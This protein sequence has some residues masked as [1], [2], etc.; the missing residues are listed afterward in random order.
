MEVDNLLADR[1]LLCRTGGGGGGN[2]SADMASSCRLLCRTLWPP[3]YIFVEEPG[4]NYLLNEGH[5]AVGARV[6]LAIQR[7]EGDQWLDVVV[8]HPISL[9]TATLNLRASGVSAVRDAE[10]TKRRTYGATAQRTGV[11]FIPNAV[12][13]FELRGKGARVFLANLARNTAIAMVVCHPSYLP[14]GSTDGT[15]IPPPPHAPLHHS[16]TA[17]LATQWTR[18]S[19]RACC[20]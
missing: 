14:I 7:P 9:G 5:M 20:L 16:L 1:L 18:R 10:A 2:A 3:P 11:S 4:S 13:T 19:G 15:E 8:V 17:A 6:D 12:D